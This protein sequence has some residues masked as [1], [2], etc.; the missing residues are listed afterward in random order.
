MT[1]AET[2]IAGKQSF[3]GYT[4]VAQTNNNHQIDLRFNGAR[5]IARINDSFNIPLS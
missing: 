2:A 3:L 4:P 1:A 5:V